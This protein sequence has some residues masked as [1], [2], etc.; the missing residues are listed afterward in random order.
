MKAA[1]VHA[2]QRCG[3]ALASLCVL[4]GWPVQAQQQAVPPPAP[5]WQEIFA[6]PASIPSPAGNPVSTERAALGARLFTDTR[7]SGA[8]DRSCASCHQ[9]TRAFTDGRPRARP[10]DGRTM[11]PNTPAIFDLAWAKRFHWDGRHPTLEAQARAPIVHPQELAGSLE[12]TARRLR[13]DPDMQARFAAAFPATRRISPDM[14]PKA[15]AAYVRT[16]ISPKTRFDMWIEGRADALT[17]RE[18]EGF[19]LFAGRAGCLACHG[20]WRFTDGRFHDIGLATRDL[21]RNAANPALGPSFKTPGLR[22]VSKTAP[23]MHDGSVGTLADVIDHYVRGKVVRPSLAVELRRR[24]ELT[25]EERDAL[26][27][28]LLTL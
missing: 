11:L 3:G 7:L 24:V 13:K 19:R 27:A 28:F 12:Q 8:E 10:L 16:L 22:Q 2:T 4:Y 20:G 9:P 5:V 6:R 15:L 1:L 14:V 17:R 18:Y 21:G 23:Y 26:I 25:T